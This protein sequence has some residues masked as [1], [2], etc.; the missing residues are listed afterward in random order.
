MWTFIRKLTIDKKKSSLIVSLGLLE[1]KG[2]S[3][4]KI[5]GA[6]ETAI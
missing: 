2:K 6:H 3:E 1:N 5:R 4:W